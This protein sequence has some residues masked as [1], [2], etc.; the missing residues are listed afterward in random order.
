MVTPMRQLAY[1]G[2]Y[3][4]R[5]DKEEEERVW[6]SFRPALI[7]SAVILTICLIAGELM[8]NIEGTKTFSSYTKSS[9]QS[10]SELRAEL[11]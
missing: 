6:S 4:Y 8:V 10:W 2:Y 5:S 11:D 9:S 7:W 3:Y 1:P